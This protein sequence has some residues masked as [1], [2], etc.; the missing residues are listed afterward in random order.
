VPAAGGKLARDAR[1]GRRR[2][3]VAA[4]PLAVLAG[5]GHRAVK[6][7]ADC[8]QNAGLAG[9]GGAVEEEQTMRAQAVEVN[10]FGAGEGAEG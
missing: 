7:E 5:T 10:V 2:G 6:G 8:V 4:Q 9:T 1:L 3:V